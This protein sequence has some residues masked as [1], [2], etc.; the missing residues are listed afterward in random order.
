MIHNVT[1]FRTRL[2]LDINASRSSRF[3]DLAQ[4][5]LKQGIVRQTPRIGCKVISD[6][7]IISLP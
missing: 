4:T 6:L 2:G 1:I 3:F 5:S 7:F